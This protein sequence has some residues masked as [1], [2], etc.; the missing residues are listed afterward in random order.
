[1]ETTSET[2]MLERSSID[3][4]FIIQELFAL[5]LEEIIQ[6]IFLFL[7]PTSLKNA[8]RTCIEWK[9]FIDRR[10]WKSKSGMVELNRKLISQW[11][12]DKPEKC[13]YL[14][15]PDYVHFLVC[16]NQRVVAALENGTVVGYDSETLDVLYTFDQLQDHGFGVQ[17]DMNED[18]LLIMF[19][20]VLVILDKTTGSKLYQGVPLDSTEV[21]GIK[22]IKNTAVVGDNHGNICFVKNEDPEVVESWT[23]NKYN[24]SNLKGVTHIEGNNDFLTIGTR[25]GIYLWDVKTMKLVESSIG[26]IK[27]RVWMLTMI[28]PFVF[29][30]G[31]ADFKGLKVYNLESGKCIRDYQYSDKG[32]HNVHTNGRFLIISEI[33]MVYAFWNHQGRRDRNVFLT[34]D[35][36]ELLNEKIPDKDLWVM[37]QEKTPFHSQINAVS[38]KT[39]IFVTN[40]RKLTVYDCWRDRVHDVIDDDDSAAGEINFDEDNEEFLED[41][42]DYAVLAHHHLDIEEIEEA[43]LHYPEDDNHIEEEILNPLI[44]SSDD[45][46]GETNGN[47]NDS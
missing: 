32:F 10:I 45:D 42:E 30:V 36:H 41:F 5:E 26:K 43:D 47:D 21:F 13:R 8:R 31:G 19:G 16:D 35:I 39:K 14:M 2:E 44:S 7:D 1:M 4:D 23:V 27:A 25:S 3:T 29:V 28:Y 9:E 18:H 34:L 38:N 11:K 20:T 37:E 22:M 40:R 24:D 12:S 15:L 6:K 33:N 17:L 46:E